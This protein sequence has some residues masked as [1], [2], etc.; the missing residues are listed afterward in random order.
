MAVLEKEMGYHHKI[1]LLIHNCLA[2]SKDCGEKKEK[3]D[4]D[5]FFLSELHIQTAAIG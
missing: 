5:I 1:A 2:H 4:K 3:N